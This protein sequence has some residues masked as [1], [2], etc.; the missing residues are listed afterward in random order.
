M[1]L[2]NLGYTLSKYKLIFAGLTIMGLL[3]GQSSLVNANQDGIDDNTVIIDGRVY[4]AED[5]LEIVVE[6]FEVGAG[7][8]Q[9]V[10]VEYR[11]FPDFGVSPQYEWGSSYAHSTE[12]LQFW[13]E[14]KGKAAANVYSGK[15]IIQVCFWWTR[16]GNSVTDQ[17][18][19]SATSNGS[20]WTAGSEKTAWT[21]DSWGWNDQP[22]IFNVK[23]TRIN[24]G[25]L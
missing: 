24:P 4:G 9:T 21:S 8:L 25:V 18:C 22:T 1:L 19:S 3:I 6:S 10:G 15:R 14:G 2:E 17:T 20:Y 5:G 13:Y 11:D 23:T 7:G 12:W 16:G